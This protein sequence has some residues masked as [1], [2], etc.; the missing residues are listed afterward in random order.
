MGGTPIMAL[1]ILGM[2]VGKIEPRDVASILKGGA[3][4]CAEAGI[5]VAGGHSIDNPE[6]VYGLAVMGICR[7]D[8]I[9]RNRDRAAG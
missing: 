3:T 5:P 8:H 7:R 2:P 6:P 1:A 9:R 4:I